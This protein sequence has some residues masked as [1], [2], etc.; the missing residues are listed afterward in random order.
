MSQIDTMK[1]ELE[2]HGATGIHIRVGSKH[3]RLCWTWNGKEMFHVISKSSADINQREMLA[4]QD[5]RRMLGVNQGSGPGERRTRKTFTRKYQPTIAPDTITVKS[6][7]MAAL[8]PLK[9][10]LEAQMEQVEPIPAKRPGRQ[11]KEKF[12][13]PAPTAREREWLAE[14]LKRGERERH[15]VAKRLV[16]PGLAA[17]M[18]ELNLVNRPIT[19]HQVKL[20][21]ARLRRGDFVLTHQGI[22]FAKTNVLNDGQHRLLA[23]ARS[24]VTAPLQITFGAEREEFRLID[25]GRA[26]R[27]GDI[28]GVTVKNQPTLRASIARI[29][30]AGELRIKEIDPQMVAQK[31]L[32][33]QALPS[34]DVAMALAWAM[35]KVC[36]PTPPAAAY[37]WIAER[38]PSRLRVNEFFDGLP[39]GEGLVGVKLKLREWLRDA[40]LHRVKAAGGEGFW[41]TAG[42]ILAWNAWIND[43]TRAHSMDWRKTFGLPEPE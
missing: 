14:M 8:L 21:E 6:N 19:E 11:P 26:R 33:M 30:V 2:S 42:I 1:A 28:V 23:I 32:E 9:E 36:N 3:N 24:G 16:S 34:T 5:I 22:S 4:V 41:R 31:A 35:K 20:H 39:S 13:L 29:I 38:S 15:I 40:N 43:K 25:A 7:P 37:C 12:I 17:A 18:L 10:K 27:A